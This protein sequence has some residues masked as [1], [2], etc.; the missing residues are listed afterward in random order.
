MKE[1]LYH[2]RTLLLLNDLCRCDCSYL[3]SLLSRICS[4]GLLRL[5]QCCCA[6]GSDL[7]SL[8]ACHSEGEG[9]QSM[10]QIEAVTWDESM[11]AC[12]SIEF[13]SEVEIEKAPAR[14]VGIAFLN[15]LQFLVPR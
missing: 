12:K 9:S 7:G 13:L 8:A 6:S 5:K 10:S 2:F 1:S 4:R 15:W 3:H 14:H 11:M